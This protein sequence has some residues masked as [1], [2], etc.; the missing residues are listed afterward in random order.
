MKS[1]AG[2]VEVN[3]KEKKEVKTG[4]KVELNRSKRTLHTASASRGRLPLHAFE[5]NSWEPK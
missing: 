4:T 1:S 2:S 3:R 5:E